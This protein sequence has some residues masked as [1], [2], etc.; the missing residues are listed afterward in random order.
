MLIVRKKKKKEKKKASPSSTVDVHSPDLHTGGSHGIKMLHSS[1]TD[2]IKLHTLSDEN[3]L[4]ETV[5]KKNTQDIFGTT[6]FHVS[7]VLRAEG[8]RAQVSTR[9]QRRSSYTY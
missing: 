4:S 3:N 6:E 2:L 7:A 9:I 1:C 5:R 8:R